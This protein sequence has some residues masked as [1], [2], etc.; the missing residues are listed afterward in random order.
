MN[1]KQTLKMINKEIKHAAENID[2]PEKLQKEFIVDM[3]KNGVKQEKDFSDKTGTNKIIYLKRIATAA[4]AVF[5]IT[6]ISAA[7]IFKEKPFVINTDGTAESGFNMNSPLRGIKS[8]EEIEQVVRNIFSGKKAND[9][10]SSENSGKSD[11]AEYVAA[12]TDKNSDL[13]HGIVDGEE[14]SSSRVADIV[15]NDGKYLYIV[16]SCTDRE[17]GTS[18]E[19]IKI[20]RAVPAEEMKTVSTITLSDSSAHKDE[21]FDIYLKGN[22]LIALIKRYSGNPSDSKEDST[23]ALF[24]DISDPNSPVKTR[25]H[26]QDGSYVTSKIYGGKLCLITNKQLSESSG[27]SLSVP[28]FSVNGVVSR[29]GAENILMSVNDPEGSYL[30]ITLTDI[31]DLSAEVGKLA[32]LGSGSNIYCS[33]SSVYVSRA[34]VSVEADEQGN[35]NNLTE[36]YKINCSASGISL[37]GSCTLEGNVPSSAFMDESGSNL[38]VAALNS[39]C[40]NIYVLNGKMEVIGKLEKAF[41]ISFIPNVKF[42]A[43]KAYIIGSGEMT[44]IDLSDPTAPASSVSEKT[45]NFGLD[46]FKVSASKYISISHDSSSGCMV[47]TLY[48]VNGSGVPTAAS[49]YSLDSTFSFPAANDTKSL[50]IING[51]DI[52]GIP[53]IKSNAATGS[54]ISEYILFNTSDG[55]ISPLGTYDHDGNYI[56]DAAVR[57]ENIG[58][59]LYTISGEK[60]VAFSLADASKLSTAEIR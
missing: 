39:N 25:E 22:T 60:V 59:T 44:V 15:K 10:N 49:T 37:S 55:I 18:C 54:E 48:N 3:L 47:I 2:V 4:A 56:G 9:S 31:S 26:I 7:F 41:N 42:I 52:F 30:F 38:R 8:I 51:K 50:M 58:N 53:V 40:G 33:S 16:T 28:A 29:P 43:D 57:A 6:V 24:Y 14:N 13:N 46:L 19:Q 27:D 11:E 5:F 1:D 45:G 34:F 21:C 36:I 12:P 23:I 20:V 32:I 35:K 17:K